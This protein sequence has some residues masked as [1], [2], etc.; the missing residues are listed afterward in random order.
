MHA[1][2]ESIIL[3]QWELWNETLYDILIASVSLSPSQMD[4]VSKSFASTSDGQ[5]FY[6]WV[7][8]HA[9]NRKES[10]QIRLKTRLRDLKLTADM[11]SDQV[12]AVLEDLGNI[13]PQIIEHALVEDWSRPAIRKA[14][15][16]FPAE[17]PDGAVV[18]TFPETPNRQPK[19][20]FQMPHFHPGPDE[21]VHSWQRMRPVNQR[22]AASA[23]LKGIPSVR[24]FFKHMYWW[25]QRRSPSGPDQE[26]QES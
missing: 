1:S 26:Q 24:N 10:A 15:S 23:T 17:H 25:S 12:K 20:P 21:A 11:S 16:L 13:W 22:P 5:A 18:I 8:S 7:L 6:R 3:A 4:H 2:K 14:L 9:D 19:T